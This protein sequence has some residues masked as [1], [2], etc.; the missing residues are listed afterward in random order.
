MTDKPERKRKPAT[1]AQLEALERG[2]RNLAAKRAGGGEAGPKP[3]KRRPAPP[4][5]PDPAVADDPDEEEEDFDTDEDDDD[6]DDDDDDVEA[7]A[8]DDV[9]EPEPEPAR[10]R[11]Y[12]PM[13]P[14]PDGTMLTPEEAAR[15]GAL[16]PTTLALN[17]ALDRTLRR[18]QMGGQKIPWNVRGPALYNALSELWADQLGD[19][20]KVYIDKKSPKVEHMDIVPLVNLRDF[21]DLMKYIKTRFWHGEECEYK[22][23]IYKNGHQLLGTDIIPLGVD[24]MVQDAWE[25]K[26]VQALA[27]QQRAESGAPPHRRTTG[28]ALPAAAAGLRAAAAAGIPGAAPDQPVR[29]TRQPVRTARVPAA[30]AGARLSAGRA[31]AIRAAAAADGQPVRTARQPIRPAH[32]AA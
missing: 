4:P 20:V 6:D 17:A 24:P 19:K 22:W 5:P 26:R 28:A 11:E 32:G 9:P 7:D 13:N 23:T 21:S 8:A 27:R 1:P 16:D 2:R 29:A 10:S 31:A 15:L 25:T 14:P 18:K 12:S 3:T 30:A